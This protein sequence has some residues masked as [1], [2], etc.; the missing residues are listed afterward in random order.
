VGK[1]DG[2]NDWS[3]KSPRCKRVVIADDFTGACDVGVQFRKRGMSTSVHIRRPSL[4]ELKI[5]TS[6]LLVLDTETRNKSEDTAY[7]IV[8]DFCSLCKHAKVEVVY[9]KID[10][11]LRGNLGAELEALLDVFDQRSV[12]ICPAYPQYG[13]TVVNGQLLVR[14]VPVEKTQFANDPLCPVNA[15][16][17]GALVSLQ[18]TEQVMKIPLT[19]V[20]RGS[21]YVSN[22]IRQSRSNGFRIVC[23]DAETRADLRNVASACFGSDVV[24]CG[25]A[26]LAEEMAMSIQSAR[27]KIL[28]ISAS[29]NEATLKELR[30]SAQYPR[31]LLI[32]AK[33]SVL[34]GKSKTA[35]LARIRRLV[36]HGLAS[37][38]VVIV[39]SALYQSDFDSNRT[40][41]VSSHDP[42]TNG[43]AAAISPLILS[44]PVDAVILT[45]GEMAAAFLR[46]IQTKGLRLEKE[47]LPGIPLGTVISGNSAGL[48]IVTKAGGFGLP[49][50][51]RKVVEY[52]SN[53]ES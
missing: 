28:I 13:R 37:H 53:D 29:T 7:R 50:S 16:D 3:G 46:E 20:R 4:N 18:S 41:L 5:A 6:D 25:S 24:P 36:E 43:L 51:M 38:D 35:E 22:S 45:G 47:I 9:K 42:I 48:R 26:G 17:I 8:R 2:T 32:R 31:S 44:K 12:V 23:A 21:S 52:L 15:S 30:E 34:K 14:G 10:S 33:A 39:C 11:T 1:A 40:K 27:R 19:V 49:G